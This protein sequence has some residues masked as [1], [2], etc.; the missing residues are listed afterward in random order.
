M[1]LTK[2]IQ[3]ILG[4]LAVAAVLAAGLLLGAVPLF[5]ESR[6]VEAQ[7]D[8]VVSTNEMYEVQVAQLRENQDRFDEIKESI[9][10]LRSQIPASD[11]L[12]EVFEIINSAAAATGVTIESAMAGERAVWVA[13]AAPGEEAAPGTAAGPEAA[14]P[15]AAPTEDAAASE[16]AEGASETPAE[17]EVPPD[18]EVPFTMVVTTPDTAAAARFIDALGAGPRLLSI[19]HVV[20]SETNGEF[21]LTIDALTFVRTEN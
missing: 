1:R 9:T 20:M 21:S 10:T 16:S 2:E 7:A 17:A 8:S 5:L 13:R 4:G 18:N 11:R 6:T 3:N 12:D 15:E 19:T 14:A